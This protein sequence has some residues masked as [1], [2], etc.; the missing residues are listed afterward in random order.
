MQR[1]DEDPGV[2]SI[3]CGDDSGR[4]FEVAD[5]HPR[6]ELEVDGQTEVGGVVAQ[7]AEPIDRPVLSGSGSWPTT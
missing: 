2:G 6:R 3:D 1:I 4:R 5:L 7:P